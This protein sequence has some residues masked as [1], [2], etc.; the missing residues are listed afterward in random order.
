MF[1][2]PKRKCILSLYVDDFKLACPEEVCGQVWADVAR[3]IKIG[4]PEDIG[5]YLGCQHEYNPTD[6]HL[7]SPFAAF[8]EPAGKVRTRSAFAVKSGV[9]CIG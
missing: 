9:C 3:V 1:V 5:R 8:F 2:G 7:V 4:P 6:D